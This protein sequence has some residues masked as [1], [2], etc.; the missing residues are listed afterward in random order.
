MRSSPRLASPWRCAVRGCRRTLAVS[1]I[2]ISSKG[3]F[4]MVSI[5]MGNTLNSL[6]L[7]GVRVSSLT[8]FPPRGG[9]RRQVEEFLDALEPLRLQ[10]GRGMLPCPERCPAHLRSLKKGR[11]YGS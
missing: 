5:V 11:G 4:S 7:G 10:A 2:S 3:R 8:I 9:A 1:P 6:S